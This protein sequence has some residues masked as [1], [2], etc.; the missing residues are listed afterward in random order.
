VKP[1]PTKRNFSVRLS[2]EIIKMLD[3][4]AENTGMNI[5]RN[6]VIEQAAEWAVRT[7]RANG[8]RAL[9]N[10]DFNSLVEFIQGK[11]NAGA[12]TQRASASFDSSLSTATKKTSR[13]AG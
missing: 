7:Y 11:A 3:E 2:D 6:N 1:E 5:T 12:K 8:N 4:I 9:T 13:P 10:E